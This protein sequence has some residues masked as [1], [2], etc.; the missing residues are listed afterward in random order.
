MMIMAAFMPIVGLLAT[1]VSY[2]VS[3]WVF[4]AVAIVAFVVLLAYIGARHLFVPP[5]PAGAGVSGPLI[6]A[7]PASPKPSPGPSPVPRGPSVTPGDRAP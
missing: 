3:F 2:T 4:A 1:S 7:V 5:H 6:A